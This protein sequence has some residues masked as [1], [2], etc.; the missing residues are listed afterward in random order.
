MEEIN[1]LRGSSLVQYITS[2]FE[3]F[4]SARKPWE[5]MWIELWH[6]FLGEYQESTVWRKKRRAK[7]AGAGLS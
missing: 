1:Y 6:N 2:L 7:A 3:A 5:E 4:K